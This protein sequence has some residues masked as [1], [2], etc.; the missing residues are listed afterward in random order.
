MGQLHLSPLPLSHNPSP[1]PSASPPICSFR[2]YRKLP[3]FDYVK[4]LKLHL[5][6]SALSGPKIETRIPLTTTEITETSCAV[7]GFIENCLA[8]APPEPSVYSCFLSALSGSKIEPLKTLNT[9]EI[10]ET[11][12]VSSFPSVPTTPSPQ[13]PRVE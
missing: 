7:F 2:F 3:N 6:L 13:H 12:A 9:T 11:P 4:V 5:T 8:Q 1:L 10:T